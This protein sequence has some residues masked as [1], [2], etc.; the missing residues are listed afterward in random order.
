MK[1]LIIAAGMGRRIRNLGDSKPLVE[2]LGLP[3]IERV[4]MNARRAGI[5][6]FVIVVG[7][8][9]EKVK[10]KLNEIAKRRGVKLTI[11]NN[12]DWQKENGLSVL[13]AREALE[14]EKFLLL[15]SDHIHDPEIIQS[16]VN[17]SI[18]DGEVILAVDGKV[19]RNHLVDHDDVTRV[20]VK[21]GH[22][23]DIGKNIKRFNAFDTGAF[24]CT[25]AIF[26]AIEES[27]KENKDSTLSGGIRILANRNRA[28]ALD[29]G[30]AFWIDVDDEVAYKKA[31]NYLLGKLN[32][33]SDGPVAKYL[34]RPISRL[35]TRYLVKL[36]VTPNQVTI[37]SFLVAVFAGILFLFKDMLAL[38]GILTQFSSVLDGVDGE[39]ARIKYMETKF[40][41][42]LDSVL[43]RY[44]DGIII[45]TLTWNAYH[46][47]YPS[48]L[49]LVAGWF[50]ILGSLINSYIAM[51]YDELMGK[52]RRKKYFRIGRD[53]R[54][55]FI[56]VGSLAGLPFETLI[57]LGLLMNFENLRR[58]LILRKYENYL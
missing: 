47:R 14:G 29:I 6:E 7:Y 12:P 52:L 22:I 5:T 13:K 32:K 51:K 3:L 15:M 21:D 2:L 45:G 43:D 1:A 17:A 4:I 49:T 35:I 23:Q 56:F 8:N 44:A 50:S 20:L 33:N 36:P 26:D 48:Y 40:G 9:G 27:I 10:E 16:L 57:L 34:N 41:K 39:I 19:D 28:L 58:I 42:W 55:F 25:P 30:D 37:F 11:I 24:L 53:L 38:A 31:E 18:N 54:L 46:F